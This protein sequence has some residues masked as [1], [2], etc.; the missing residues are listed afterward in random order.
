MTSSLSEEAQQ[1]LD[2]PNIAAHGCAWVTRPWASSR[3][4]VGLFI[5]ALAATTKKAPAAPETIIGSAL[6][7]CA[8]GDMR[9]QPKR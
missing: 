2:G 1:L 4:P 7:M 3:K 8:R 9:F 6:S 5:Q